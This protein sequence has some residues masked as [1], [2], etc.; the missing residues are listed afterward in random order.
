MTDEQF[1]KM[2]AVEVAK[3]A[4]LQGIMSILQGI[5]T[6]Q[7]SRASGHNWTTVADFLKQA[8][9]VTRRTGS[10]PTAEAARHPA[11]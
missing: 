3:L 8:E 4:A 2:Y 10:P 9:A 5:A 7:G 11:S 6:Q 1:D